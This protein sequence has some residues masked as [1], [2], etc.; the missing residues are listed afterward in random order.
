MSNITVSIFM[1]TYNQ[2]AFIA[3]A[4]EGVL[5]QKTTFRIQLVIGEDCSTDATRHICES[6]AAKYGDLIKLLPSPISNQ[7]LIANYMRTI[8]ACNGTYIAICD[9]DDYWIDQN[10]LQKQVDFLNS[11]PDYSIV[12]TAVQRLYPNG[13]TKE[14]NYHVNENE[15]DF[16]SLVFSNFIHSVTVLFKNLQNT[17]NPIPAWISKFSFG[18]WQTYLW[19]L[20]DGGKIHFIEDITA[21]YRMNIGISTSYVKKNSDFIIDLLNILEQLYLD[22]NFKHKQDVIAKSIREKKKNLIAC[23]NREKSYRKGWYTF[24]KEIP[25]SQHKLVLIKFYLYSLY[26]SFL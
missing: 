6:Y 11:N 26:K 24:I 18:D 23:F 19:I 4:I 14:Y 21:V 7:G 22:N 13:K 9:G 12:Y 20:K 3:Q 1:L 16:N 15:S 10:K 5:M 2:E 25:Q 17:K 8:A